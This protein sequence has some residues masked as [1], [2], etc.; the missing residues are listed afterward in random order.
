MRLRNVVTMA[1]PLIVALSAHALSGATMPKKASTVAAPH[2]QQ[3]SSG[4]A[5][6]NIYE[7]S[8]QIQIRVTCPQI[9]VLRSSTRMSSLEINQERLLLA[10]HPT[11][12]RI[13]NAYLQSWL[14][15]GQ[16]MSLT[17]EFEN[18]RDIPIPEIEIDFLDP[19]SG[20]S[21]PTLKPIP[22]TRSNVYREVGSDKFSLAAGEKTALPVA[23]LDEIVDRH[24]LDLDLCAFDAAVTL[25]SPVSDRLANSPFP[26]NVGASRIKYK[27]LLVRARFKSIFDQQLSS[28]QWVW[29]VYGQGSDGMRFWYPSKKRWDTLTCAG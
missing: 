27:S 10:Q 9:S 11:E 15:D 1:L 8:G 24:S 12:L 6:P 13:T 16:R 20:A 4:C 22:F 28:T 7:N 26:A 3:S 2:V 19:A 18:P 25:N 17:L 29:I 21:I 5:S 14:P 23:F